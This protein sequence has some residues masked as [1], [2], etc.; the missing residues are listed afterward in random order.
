MRLA[1]VR[2]VRSRAHDLLLAVVLVCAHA[3]PAL[4]GSVCGTVRD[5]DTLQPVESAGVLVFEQDG[6]YAGHVGVTDAA[7]AY[8]IDFIPPGT[9]DLHVHVDDYLV[10]ILRDVEVTGEVVDV[11]AS[12][13]LPAVVLAAPTPNPARHTVRLRVTVSESAPARL[14]VLD[15]AGRLVRGWTT[16]ALP[17]GRN[18]LTWDLSDDAGRALPPGR[19]WIRLE[20]GDVVVTRALTLIR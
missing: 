15:V 5:A 18:E 3:A 10:G 12:I 19:Y 2:R 16:D 11:D 14:T 7:G 4:A 20:A 1:L 8:C 9:Y 17:V 6:T 13:D